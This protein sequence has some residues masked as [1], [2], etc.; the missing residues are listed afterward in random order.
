MMRYGIAAALILAGCTQINTEVKAPSLKV[1]VTTPLYRSYEDLAKAGRTAVK[2][3]CRFI[4]KLAQKMHAPKT[5]QPAKSQL[6]SWIPKVEEV[7]EFAKKWFP[8]NSYTWSGDCS[9]P[10]GLGPPSQ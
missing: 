3:E 4:K 10:L 6:H 7:L 9:N 1:V 8:T 5:E 2:T